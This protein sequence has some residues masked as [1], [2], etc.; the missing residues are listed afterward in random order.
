MYS[1]PRV[2]D[3]IHGQGQRVVVS[4]VE[5]G[6]VYCQRWRGDEPAKLFR[7]TISDFV[8]AVN[9]DAE[10]IERVLEMPR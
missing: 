4:F 3:Q 6:N 10:S 9:R 7:M 8:G 5:N 2:G 1:S